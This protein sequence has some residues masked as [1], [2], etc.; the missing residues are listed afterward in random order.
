MSQSNRELKYLQTVGSLAQPAL[1]QFGIISDAVEFGHLILQLLHPSAQP[2]HL[3]S[4]TARLAIRHLTGRLHFLL[5][6][7]GCGI[8]LEKKTNRYTEQVY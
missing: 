1:L 4:Q 7:V 6:L 5:L 2:L 3:L 8:V